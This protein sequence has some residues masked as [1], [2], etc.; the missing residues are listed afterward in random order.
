[1]FLRRTNRQKIITTQLLISVKNVAEALLVL[2]AG[3]DIIDLKDPDLGALG[4]LDL[5]LTKQIIHT[6]RHLQSTS[7][8]AYNYPY[9]SA[10]VG[11]QAIDLNSLIADIEARHAL[12]LDMI[13]IV[14][15]KL[16]DDAH[17][18]SKMQS[19][20][21]KG[22]KL[23]AVFFADEPLNLDLLPMLKQIGFFG[24]MLDTQNKQQNLLQVQTTEA[25]QNFTQM[26]HLHHLQS[27]LAGS[28]QAL[29]I[30]NLIQFNPTYIGFRGG[31]CENLARKTNLNRAKIIE[32]EK[33]LH[34]HNKI[35][36][37]AQK[38]Q[39]LALHS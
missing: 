7:H 35:N 25:L 31:A 27:G 3:V 33:L 12:G 28:L 24:A 13:K 2:E 14:V 23:V 32:L 37:K 6:I 18:V 26:C 19:L 30:E 22:I 5:Q 34:T 4:A 10:A 17:F 1:M 15:S 11:D 29:H 20:T 21:D 36:L 8:L 39:H 16:F 38:S 9:F